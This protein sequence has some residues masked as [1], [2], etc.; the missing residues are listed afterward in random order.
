[1]C[2]DVRIAG[3][4]AGA[5]V[6]VNDGGTLVAT[7]IDAAGGEPHPHVATFEVAT[8]K[9]LALVRPSAGD[10]SYICPYPELLGDVLLEVGT[11]C[12]GPGA[13]GRFFDAR[14]GRLLGTLR[15]RRAV[16]AYGIHP[17]HV[18]G[19]V[20]AFAPWDSDRLILE[21]V[22]TMKVSREIT[23]ADHPAGGDDEAGPRVFVVGDH[24][25]VAY[26]LGGVED[27]DLVRGTARKLEQRPCGPGEPR[28]H[29]PRWDARPPGSDPQRGL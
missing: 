1:V 12:A 3:V 16:N 15:G 4:S 29:L 27:V 26:G 18:R 11:V 22:R 7:V 21:D 19:N 28:W 9:A 17:A 13:R 6:V 2:R 23:L 10:G 14:S 25:L 8:G 24:A 5:D 20:W